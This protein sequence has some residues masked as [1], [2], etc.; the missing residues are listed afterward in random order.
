MERNKTEIVMLMVFDSIL[1]LAYLAL[2]W[3]SLSIPLVGTQS[4]TGLTAV[5][6]LF[7][8][9]SALDSFGGMNYI[10]GSDAG[11]YVIILIIFLIVWFLI[12]F[13]A[14]IALIKYATG[15]NEVSLRKFSKI[16]YIIAIVVI[17]FLFSFRF[18]I[19]LNVDYA[20]DIISNAFKFKIGYYLTFIIALLGVFTPAIVEKIERNGSLILGE[21]KISHLRKNFSPGR[22]NSEETGNL[23]PVV[24][25]ENPQNTLRIFNIPCSIGRNK[26]EVDY[27]IYHETISRKHC[28]LN[29]SEGRLVVRDI[30]S[31]HGVSINGEQI[32]QNQYYLLYDGDILS[33][34]NM[35]FKIT[36][37]QSLLSVYNKKKAESNPVVGN[38]ATGS[39]ENDETMILNE[40]DTTVLSN[41]MEEPFEKRRLICENLPEKEKNEVCVITKTPFIIGKKASIVDY[42]V[43]DTGVSR[44]HCKI[45]EIDSTFYIEDL[46]STNGTKINDFKI[47][48]VTPLNEGDRIKIGEHIYRFE[49]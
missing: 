3:I 32:N 31:V 44:Q 25:L 12:P 7:D 5:T 36:I 41:D 26:E 27:Y 45:K 28:E 43:L 38:G 20:S 47:E 40:E 21:D 48:K 24:L 49:K 14:S 46:N 19:I 18:I 39:I 8:G 1:I 9:A 35:Q 30:G 13:Y 11:G 42:C 33:L 4:V 29:L 34:G 16:S 17:V 15:R 10:M 23:L 6:S 37:D 2:P 22:K